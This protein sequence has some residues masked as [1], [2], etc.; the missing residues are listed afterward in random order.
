MQFYQANALCSFLN[1][2]LSRIL[3]IN[4]YISKS[5]LELSGIVISMFF[6]DV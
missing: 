1:I 3:K 4:F 2:A 6:K 5:L